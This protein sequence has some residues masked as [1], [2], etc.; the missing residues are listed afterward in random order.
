M[1]SE[2]AG[3]GGRTRTA[4]A[5]P[6][7]SALNGELARLF[8][9]IEGT[10]NPPT[11]QALQAVDLLKQNLESKR[12]SWKDFQAGPLKALNGQL[13]SQTLPELAIPKASSASLKGMSANNYDADAD[14]P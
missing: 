7:L 4:S 12:I 11:T 6:S 10:D 3:S 13:R 1:L 5:Q 9:I 2:L 14:E 8:E